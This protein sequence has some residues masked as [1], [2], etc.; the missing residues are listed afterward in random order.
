[1]TIYDVL[2]QLVE[3]ADVRP[4]SAKTEMREAIDEAERAAA[5]T[6]PAIKRKD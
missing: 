4:P 2:R 3:V 5:R 1:M 6:S